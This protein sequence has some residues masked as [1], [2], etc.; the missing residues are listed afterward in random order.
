MEMLGLKGDLKE[1]R[2]RR[3]GVDNEKE[4]AAAM[5]PTALPK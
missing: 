5:A 4:R 1:K 2:E 3:E